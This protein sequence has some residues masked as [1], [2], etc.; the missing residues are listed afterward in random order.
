MF[1]YLQIKCFLEFQVAVNALVGS[2]EVEPLR[3]S[4][5]RKVIRFTQTSSAFIEV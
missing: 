4:R 3:G 5:V 1:W 2:Y